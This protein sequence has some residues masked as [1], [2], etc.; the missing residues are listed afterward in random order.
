M[1]EVSLI[2]VLLWVPI[3]YIGFRTIIFLALG[4]GPLVVIPTVYRLRYIAFAA[5]AAGVGG[6]LML[7]G[8]QF[9]CQGARTD[10]CIS[11]DPW[12]VKLELAVY[13]LVLFVGSG[14]CIKNISRFQ[15]PPDRPR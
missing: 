12:P 4:L 9:E 3:G 5:F 8:G 1:G 2:R 15:L 14:A 6:L 11:S 10:H 13:Y 7:L